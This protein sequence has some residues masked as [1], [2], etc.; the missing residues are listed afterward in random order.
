MGCSLEDCVATENGHAHHCLFPR[1]ITRLR[2]DQNSDYWAKWVTCCKMKHKTSPQT[3][4][5]DLAWRLICDVILCTRNWW[6][7]EKDTHVCLDTFFT[8]FF[9][10]FSLTALQSNSHPHFKTEKLRQEDRMQ[11]ENLNCTVKFPAPT[12]ANDATRKPMAGNQH[13]CQSRWPWQAFLSTASV[14]PHSPSPPMPDFLP[15]ASL[16]TG[17]GK[18]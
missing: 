16:H 7:R 3:Q 15:H 12:A 1:H 6:P 14:P 8:L 17:N 10:C 2:K 5:V 18:M 9:F 11:W 4:R 13:Q